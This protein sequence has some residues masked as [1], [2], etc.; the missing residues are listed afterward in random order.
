MSTSV[1]LWLLPN[2]INVFKNHAVP[3]LL[4]VQPLGEVTIAM[5]SLDRLRKER[6]GLLERT[7]EGETYNL[8]GDTHL[9]T[10]MSAKLSEQM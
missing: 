1:T 7:N 10:V 4:L 9:M 2:G 3:I 6:M 8:E 5:I